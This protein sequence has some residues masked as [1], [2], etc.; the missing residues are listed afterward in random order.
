[1][2]KLLIILLI[3]VV[4]F[5]KAQNHTGYPFMLVPDKFEFLDEKDEYSMNSLAKFL[6][7]KRGFK[8]FLA[9]DDKPIEYN[10]DECGVLKF[11]LTKEK[12]FI[13]TKLKITITDCT[14]K[15]IAES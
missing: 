9:S 8:A 13:H 1:M 3:G 14:N 11:N 7:E 4:W 15:V 6:L 2:R 12:T 10:L 5:T